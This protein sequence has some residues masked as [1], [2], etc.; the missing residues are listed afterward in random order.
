M[1]TSYPRASQVI[2]VP[3][4]S[5]NATVTVRFHD[6]YGQPRDL[7]GATGSILFHASTEGGTAVTTNA[8]AAF[9][10]DGSDGKVTFSLTST[11][12]G[13]ARN[14][15][16]EFEVQGVGSENLISEM[17]LLMVTERAKVV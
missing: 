16:C 2:R 6:E 15:R 7:S 10:S 12:V 4:D 5:T 11:E 13:T 14:L 8:S 9:A 17:F 3:K 1:A